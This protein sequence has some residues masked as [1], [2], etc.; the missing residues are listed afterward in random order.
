KNWKDKV[1]FIWALFLCYNTNKRLLIGGTEMS[2][3]NDRGTKKWT[4]MM[5]PEHEEMLQQMWDEQKYKEKPILDEQKQF[6]IN[7]KLQ[8]AINNDL[9]VEVEYYDH[10]VHD[11]QTIKGKLIM[12]DNLAR[13]LR[14]DDASSTVVSLNDVMEVVVD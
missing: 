12:V 13:V 11:F 8:L 7:S 9:T 6:E 3:V 1:H 2:S 10:D 4:A 5:I 14:F